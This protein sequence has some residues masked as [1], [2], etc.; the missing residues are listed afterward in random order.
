MNIKQERVKAAILDKLG[1]KTMG[2]ILRDAGYT[3]NYADNPAQFFAT[4]D[5]KE[6]KGGMIVFIEKETKAIMLEMEGKREDAK[7]RDLSQ[8]LVDLK[9]MQQLL[10]GK[11]TENIEIDS[12]IL[13]IN[14]YL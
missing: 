11:P 7:Y 14:K 3:D 10:E 8:T 6:I 4:E 9:K 13:Q 2:Q 5:G 1:K 12:A